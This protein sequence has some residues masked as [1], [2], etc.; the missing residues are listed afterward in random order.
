[1]SRSSWNVECG[2][3]RLSSGLR[4][5]KCSFFQRFLM[6]SIVVILYFSPPSGVGLLD[7]KKKSTPPPSPP[8]SLPVKMSINMSIE[9]PI[10]MSIEMSIKMSIELSAE[11]PILGTQ[12]YF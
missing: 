1:M 3:G 6:L 10:E 12:R 11:N 8:S 5:A 7:F 2:E 9:M 4:L